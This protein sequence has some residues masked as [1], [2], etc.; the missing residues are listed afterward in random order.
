MAKKKVSKSDSKVDFQ[1]KVEDFRWEVTKALQD[2]CNQVG[3][4]FNTISLNS[5]GSEGQLVFRFNRMMTQEEKDERRNFKIRVGTKFMI[6][7]RTFEVTGYRRRNHKYPVLARRSDGTP[8]KVTRKSV[9]EGLIQEGTGA[10]V[11]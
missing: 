11:G 6:R 10:V 7:N 1:L 3:V 8:F 4:E 5:T 9:I 2:V